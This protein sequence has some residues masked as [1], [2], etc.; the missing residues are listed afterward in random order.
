MFF[1]N[2]IRTPAPTPSGKRRLPIQEEEDDLT[3][4]MEDPPTEP[5]IQEVMLPRI[6]PNIKS[7]RDSELLPVKGGVMMDIEEEAEV[8]LLDLSCAFLINFII[9]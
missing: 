6:I 3:K 8:G 1:K 5:A 4:D 9:L 2:S 7:N